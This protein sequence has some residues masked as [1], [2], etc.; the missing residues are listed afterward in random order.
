VIVMRTFSKI[1]GLA[2]L[3]LGYAIVHP[4]L[5]PHINAVQEPFNVNRAA[6]AAGLASLRRVDQLDARREQVRDARRALVEPLR[7][8][9][10]RC[11][12]SDA[13]FVLIEVGSEE[14]NVFDV[15]ARD[16]LLVRP[17]SEVGLPGHIRVT[18]GAEDLMRV[19]ASRIAD[20]V[21]QRA[22]GTP[23]RA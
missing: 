10:I 9:G 6:L 20:V 7:A 2:G 8:A 1:F 11:L 17:G 15:L 13:N 22:L 21:G 5:A 12:D 16:G 23:S 14:E 4:S 19:V 18:T 3:R